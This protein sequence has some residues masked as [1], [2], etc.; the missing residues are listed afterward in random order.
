M[1]V[2]VSTLDTDQLVISRHKIRKGRSMYYIKI[3]LIL[4]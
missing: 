4:I 1:Y 2:Y 3:T